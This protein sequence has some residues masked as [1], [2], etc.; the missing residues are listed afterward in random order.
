MNTTKLFINTCALGIFLIIL[1]SSALSQAQNDLEGVWQ[2]TEFSFISDDTSYSI[3]SPQPSLY[4]FGKKYYSIMYVQGEQPRPLMPE[5]SYRRTLTDKNIRDIFMPFIANSG[6][7]TVR[8]SKITYNPIVALEPNFMTGGSG[9]FTFN[10]KDGT[11]FLTRIF[12]DGAKR[13]I[14]LKRL[15]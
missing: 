4:I 1:S 6:V 15:E 5:G 2:Q 9:Q 8:G 10:I 13:Y 14:K 12:E 3:K 11:L 7:Y